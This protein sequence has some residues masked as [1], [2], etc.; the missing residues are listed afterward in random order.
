MEA[1]SQI[2]DSQR[3]VGILPG[4][5]KLGSDPFG[6]RRPF[7]SLETLPQPEQG[8]AVPWVAVE[9][10]SKHPFGLC[11]LLVQE[12][13]RAQR[14]ANRVV[15]VRGLIVGNGILRRDGCRATRQVCRKMKSDRIKKFKEGNN[16]AVDPVCKMTVDEKKAAA[17]SQY[18]GRTIY[19]C[20]VGCKQKFDADPGKVYQDGLVIISVIIPTL[21]EAAGIRETLSALKGARNAEVIVADGGSVDGTRELAEPLV[22]RLVVSSPGRGRQMNAGAGASKG[23]ALLFLHADTRLP[24]GWEGAIRNAL[25]DDA[26]AGGAFELS[27][28]SNRPA[29]G[30][31]ARVANA[32]SRLTRVPYGDQAVFV[33]RA[34]FERLGGFPEIPIMED[35]VFGRKLKRAGRVT[36]IRS[37]VRTS[38]RRWEAE[39]LI[40]ATLRNWT[41]AALFLLGVRPEHLARWYR[42]VRK[43]KGV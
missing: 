24:A 14:F 43:E 6:V 8:P 33:R 7:L 42:D 41:L 12:K 34:V 32:R 17:M 10:G 21:N 23:E 22:D 28:A 2:L 36:I 13:S 30:W 27:I 18:K 38:A 39:G 35:V 20:A 3:D 4:S 37:P 31:I 16:M 26:V 1:A 5:F 40:Y 29:L 15:P 9:V 25:S 11:V 19:F